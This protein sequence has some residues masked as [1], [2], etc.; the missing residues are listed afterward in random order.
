M[1]SS[2]DDV[3]ARDNWQ[4]CGVDAPLEWTAAGIW[5]DVLSKTRRIL[6]LS[7]IVAALHK[8]RQMIHFGPWRHIAIG[9][10]RRR[11]HAQASQARIGE[12]IVG[13]LNPAEIVA[14]LRNSG[15]VVGGLLPSEFVQRVRS[16]TDRLPPNEYLLVHEVDEDLESLTRDPTLWRILREYFKCEPVLLEASLSVTR[17]EANSLDCDQNLFHFDYAGW[18]SLN[19]FVY[20][21]DVDDAA[22]FHVVARGSHVGRTL[23]EIMAGPLTDKQGREKFGSQLLDVKGQ[24]GTFFFENT[25]AFHRRRRGNQRRVMLNLL[26]ASH[27]SSLSYGRASRSQLKMR[28]R[29]YSKVRKALGG[30][31]CHSACENTG[32]GDHSRDQVL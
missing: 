25:E 31:V 27:R 23:A 12:S 29:E 26:F 14:E 3:C 13:D 20:L 5:S 18:E 28:D 19:V 6:H 10:I 17:A 8:V 22:S 2:E 11:R 30:E 15:V 9:V 24:A 32:A 1:R 16:R 7:G 21:T 4:E